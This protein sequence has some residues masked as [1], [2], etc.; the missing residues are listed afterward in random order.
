[1]TFE[2]KRKFPRHHF[3]AEIQ[4][5][6]DSPRMKARIAD[7]SEGGIFIDTVTPLENNM[8]VNFSFYIPDSNPSFAISGTGR[9]AWVD[10]TVGMGIEFLEVDE[11]SRR[12]IADFL[13]SL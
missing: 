11:T 9:V 8:T 5:K 13:K 2:E 4:Y 3:I 12:R 10:R 6:S 1:M 7:I